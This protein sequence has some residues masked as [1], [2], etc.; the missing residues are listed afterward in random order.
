MCVSYKILFPCESKILCS[1]FFGV[2]HIFLVWNFKDKK[3]F[4]SKYVV[5][6]AGKSYF[7]Q[8]NTEF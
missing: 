7:T 6:N 2:N 8:K 1:H 3:Y 4:A 5:I